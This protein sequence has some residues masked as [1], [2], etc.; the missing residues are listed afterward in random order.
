MSEVWPG[1]CAV[2]CDLSVRTNIQ[3]HVWHRRRRGCRQMSPFEIDILLWYHTRP[4]DHPH[5]L[6]KMESLYIHL[7]R[8][9]HNGVMVNKKMNAPIQLTELLGA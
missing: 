7:F 3:H 1:Q 5:M 2:R 6:N 4:V 8:P 9:K